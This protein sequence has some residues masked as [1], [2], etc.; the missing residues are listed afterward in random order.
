MNQITADVMG[1]TIV[2]AQV[3]A[4][5]TVTATTTEGTAV[6]LVS[7]AAVTSAVLN[8]SQ[9]VKIHFF[10]PHV[11]LPASATAYTRVTLFD[12]GTSLG[13]IGRWGT[14]TGAGSPF[15]GF[16]T[17]QGAAAPTSGT[18]TYVVK[19][20]NDLSGTSVVFN[21]NA[22]GTGVNRPMFLHVMPA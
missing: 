15:N 22:G 5:V 2:Y 6:T 3:T 9:G 7:C 12:G 13:D 17:L 4:A 18:H 11:L 14:D 19:A 8:G 16:A 10:C 1:P 20:Y 21:A